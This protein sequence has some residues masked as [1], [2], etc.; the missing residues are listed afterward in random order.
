MKGTEEGRVE[1]QKE[2]KRKEDREGSKVW[3]GGREVNIG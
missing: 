3:Q 1:E 2:G